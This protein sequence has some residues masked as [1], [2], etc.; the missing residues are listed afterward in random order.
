MNKAQELYDYLIKTGLVTEEELN[1]WVEEGKVVSPPV[2]DGSPNLAYEDQYQ[3]NGFI[4][5]F[6]TAK[7]DLRKVK[8]AILWWINVYQPDRGKDA[9][10]WE[11]S[12][13]N[14]ETANVWFGVAVTEKVVLKDGK[15]SACIKPLLMQ[16]PELP[17]IPVWLQDTSSGE[18]TLLRDKLDE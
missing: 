14:P 13:L 2:F 18:E 7:R 5:N 4:E 17:D 6:P 9:F 11:A 16:N 10:G 15:I 8:F 1:V 12:N 3:I